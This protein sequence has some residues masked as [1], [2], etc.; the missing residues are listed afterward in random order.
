LEISLSGLLWFKDKEPNR[1][2]VAKFL[3]VE[4][5]LV[6]CSKASALSVI[7]Q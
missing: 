5:S 4:R 2:L 1:V 3:I 7:L 6:H